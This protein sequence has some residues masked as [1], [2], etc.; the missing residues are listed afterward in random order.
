[1]TKSR[2]YE[3]WH[4]GKKVYIGE[5]EDPAQRAEQHKQ[6]GK[7]FDRL[8]VTSRS[9]KK[10][11]AQKREADRLEVYRRGHGGKNPRYNKSDDG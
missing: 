2:T 3:L 8:S 11:N 5:S 4:K 7:R 10:E 9:M 6:Q 1:M